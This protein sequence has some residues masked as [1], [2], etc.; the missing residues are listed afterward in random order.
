MSE[1]LKPGSAGST[2]APTQISSKIVKV[3]SASTLCRG[4]SL[5]VTRSGDTVRA[6]T[7]SGAEQI[8]ST[9]L[10]LAEQEF[11]PDIGGVGF[12]SQDVE[13]IIKAEID[14]G[15]A[16]GAKVMDVPDQGGARYDRLVYWTPTISRWVLIPLDGTAAP[17]DTGDLTNEIATPLLAHVV[18][19]SNQGLVTVELTVEVVYF[20][21]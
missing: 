6:M 2:T 7:T 10:A 20:N 5:L 13:W 19:T 11:P 12:E 17:Y 4:D 9:T 16:P 8:C 1:E 18:G 21:A 14:M 15:V 3:R